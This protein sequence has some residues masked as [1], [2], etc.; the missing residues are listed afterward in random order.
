MPVETRLYDVLGVSPDATLDQ[1]KKAY[2]RLAMKFHPDRN[3]NAED[4]VPPP[5]PSSLPSSASVSLFRSY[6]L[7]S[8]INA[9]SVS[10]SSSSARGRGSVN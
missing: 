2:K 6:T 4:K 1:I 5:A 9:L 10:P 3:P 8:C 7:S